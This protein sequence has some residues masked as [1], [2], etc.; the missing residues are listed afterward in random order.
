MWQILWRSSKWRPFR[1]FF[2]EPAIQKPKLVVSG[3]RKDANPLVNDKLHSFTLALHQ[4]YNLRV[5]D[6]AHQNATD[7]HAI[8]IGNNTTIIIFM[9]Y[10]MCV[11][12]TVKCHLKTTAK[13][14]KSY[15]LLPSLKLITIFCHSRSGIIPSTMSCV[16]HQKSTQFC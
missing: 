3:P 16:W 5:R 15:S 1:D 8:S 10:W 6:L 12:T 13:H 14:I 4:C 9:A 11:G 2:R 7:T